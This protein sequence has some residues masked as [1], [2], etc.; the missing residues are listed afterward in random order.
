[1]TSN[2]LPYLEIPRKNNESFKFLIDTGANK[3]YIAPEIVPNRFILSGPSQNI[4]NV[5]GKHKVNQYT[6]LNP[7]ENFIH[8]V[9]RQK[10]FLF[11]FHDFFDGLIGFE[12]LR[13]M[14]A[15][16]DTATNSII[17]ND[18]IIPLQKKFPTKEQLNF[19]EHETLVK[20]FPVRIKEGD[21]FIEND[22]PIA[23]DVILPSGVYSARNGI[24]TFLIINHSSKPVD[25]KIDKEALFT[26][27]HTFEQISPESF[28]FMDQKRE[29][30]ATIKEKIRMGHLNSE[31]EDK[32]LNV[33]KQFPEVFH[34]NDGKLT[35]SNA[36]RHPI[37]TK[38]DLPIYTKNYRYPFCHREEVQRQIA[39]MLDQ[40]IIRPSNSPWSSPIWIVPKKTDASGTQKWRLVV[41]YRKLNQK[42]T[43]DRYP[44]PNINDILDKLGKCQYFS[45][46][47]LASGFHQIEVHK[48]DIQKTAF[49]V[50]GGH[51]EFVRMPFGLKNAPATFQRVMDN[52]LREHIG[53]RCLVY[54]DD[55]IIYST[56]LQEHL[57]NL[58][59][60]LETLRKYNLKIQLDKCEFLQ[61]E[62][63]FLGHVVTPE[64]V[65]PNPEKINAIRNWPLPNNEKELRAFL[66]VIGY[67]RK[68]I[69]DFAKISKPLTQQLRKG[70]TI[71]HTADFIS[72]FQRC[73]EILTSSHV[74]QYPDFSKRFI[75]TT[76]ASNFALGAVLSQGPIGSDKPIAFA[77]RTLTQTEEKYSA[78][79][80]ELLAIDWAC[81]YFRPYLFGRKF[82]L[83]TDHKPLTY[84][85]NLKGSNDRLIR[86]K[87]RLEEFDYE[88]HYRPGKQNVIADGLS[89]I[90]QQINLN[91]QE[92]SSSS[93]SNDSDDSEDDNNTVH[94]S[95]SDSSEYIGMTERPIN[96]YKNQILIKE[97]DQNSEVY[98]EIFP[99]IF[100][101]T[102]TRFAFGIPYAIKI[103]RDYMSPTKI[104]CILCPEKWLNTLQIAY[105]NYFSR[106]KTFKLVLT[107][108]I[109]QDLITAEEQDQIIERVHQRAHRGATENYE[110]IKKEFYFPRLQKKVQEFINLC[111]ECLES[112]YERCPYKVKFA[113]TPIP[114]KPLDILHLD[115]F[116][117]S[118]NTFLSAIDKLSKFAMLIPI[119]SRSIPDVKRGIVKLIST[120]GTPKLVV[121]DN[122]AAFRS[123]EVRGFL[124]RLQVE[125]YF[126]PSNHSETNG[127]VERFH[128]TLSEIFLCIKPSYND[129]TNKELYRIATALYNSTIHAVTKLKPLEVFY[130]VKEGEE[131]TLNLERILE[132]RNHVFDEVVAKIEANQAKTIEA[133]NRVRE[134]AP[135]LKRREVIYNRIQGI[136]R[137]T[138]RRYKPQIVKNNRRKTYIDSRN[139]KLHKSKLKRRRKT[140]S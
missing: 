112:K 111:K 82:S 62:V 109:L 74:L 5:S 22:I 108:S 113:Y 66:G 102:I 20:E 67:Y 32:L 33:L 105:K 59:K 51:Y 117:S 140:P 115:I 43:D 27:I 46:I 3:N 53:V 26:E 44:I 50:D 106:N 104:N 56:S 87:L 40:G 133:R 92:S 6:F 64:G 123:I 41:D 137:K 13:S 76:D 81:K 97:G 83:Y 95:S 107:Q 24:A 129:L 84:A 36:V 57:I 45:T 77:S 28:K 15:L 42:T 86:W 34:D 75:L 101:R 19:Q 135:K 35:F 11:R 48:K 90:P 1:M 79:E 58:K 121:C 93:S 23:Q 119:K 47:D 29:S 61:K 14:G 21:F 9:P 126:T 116:I 134:D 70:E 120:F 88:I 7:I 125:M 39:K 4:K 55:I 124:Q 69:K 96:Y 110:V 2:F 118:P 94:S 98:E 80:K 37:H 8:G 38:D 139:I 89:R 17:I 114:K 99:S 30:K 122:E 63:A 136:R 10:F 65:K 85:L 12:T 31:E 131:R 49:S 73:K 68:F 100:R 132:N 91:E 130:G 60:V 138:K 103:L 72:A 78:I 18:H 16:I 71:R 54:M 128:S 25:I 52:V 127:T